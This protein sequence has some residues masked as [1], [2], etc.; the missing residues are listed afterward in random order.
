MLRTSLI[1]PA[2]NEAATI[3]EVITVARQS[4]LIDEII[5]VADACTDETSAIARGLGVHVVEK[6]TTRGKGDAMI[7]G[8]HAAKGEIL[9]FADADLEHF[10]VRHITQVIEPIIAGTAVMS[11]GLRD[12]IWGLGALVPHLLPTYAIGGERAMTK[13]FFYS[14]PLELP[15]AQGFGIET[16]M[17]YY[18]KRR[19]LAVVYPVLHGLH[20]V[21]KEKKWGFWLGIRARLGLIQQVRIAR[22]LMKSLARH[23]HS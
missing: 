19:G 17:N 23:D 9:M 7:V 13:K 1:I 15:Q 18:A 3:A 21:I 2:H 5:V 22:R 10:N 20:Q 11:I 4:P 16:I 12:R 6:P 8:A 14:L